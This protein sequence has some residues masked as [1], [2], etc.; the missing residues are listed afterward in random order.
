MPNHEDTILDEWEIKLEEK[1]VELK[2]KRG[3]KSYN[4]INF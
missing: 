4:C 2:S 1:I 3:F